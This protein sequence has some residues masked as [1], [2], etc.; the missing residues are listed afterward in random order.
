MAAGNSRPD[1]PEDPTPGPTGGIAAP[2][3]H[4]TGPG[5]TT[6][7]IDALLKVTTSGRRLFRHRGDE[8]DIRDTWPL[9]RARIAGLR[10]DAEY[11]C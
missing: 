6:L 1:R 5:S 11:R 7:G 8:A 3:G 10:A 2:Q 4:R 9:S